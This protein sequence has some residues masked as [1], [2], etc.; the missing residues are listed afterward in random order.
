M[1]PRNSGP[2]KVNVTL[3]ADASSTWLVRQGRAK[4]FREQMQQAPIAEW[5]VI[6]ARWHLG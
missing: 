1:E 4:F 5:A 6:A 3:F 2:G